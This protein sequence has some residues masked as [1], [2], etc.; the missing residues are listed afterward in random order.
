MLGDGKFCLQLPFMIRSANNQLWVA[1]GRLLLGL[2]CRSQT[3]CSMTGFA[4]TG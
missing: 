1:N 3:A 2:F 4:N